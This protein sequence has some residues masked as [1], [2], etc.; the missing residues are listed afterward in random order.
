MRVIELRDKAPT[1]YLFYETCLALRSILEQVQSII[2]DSEYCLLLAKN[3]KTLVWFTD[4][5]EVDCCSR[6]LFPFISIK[7]AY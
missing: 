4:L 6:G 3:Q 5:Q 2:P 1:E 7:V